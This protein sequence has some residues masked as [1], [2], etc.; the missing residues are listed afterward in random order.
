VRP[1]ELLL[2]RREKSR[3][4]DPDL[5]R[6]V[7]DALECA[8]C[9]DAGDIQVSV[10]AGIVAL[11][12]SVLALSDK[13]AASHVVARVEGVKG[14]ANDL[15]L[16]DVAANPPANTEIARTAVAALRWNL[17]APASAI[18]VVVDDGWL[19]LE[20]LVDWE[21]QKHIAGREVRGVAGVR[22]ITNN[23]V[24]RPGS[25]A[26]RPADLHDETLFSAKMKVH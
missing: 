7:E 4:A 24:V 10:A 15:T 5:R 17:L 20:G 2:N 16:R 11:R 6:A 23:L 1:R 25:R 8:R 9:L 13:L 22:G 19:T 26:A 14:V 18:T 21:Y 12:G 3:P